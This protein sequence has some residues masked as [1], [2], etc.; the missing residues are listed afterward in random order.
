MKNWTKLLRQGRP[1]IKMQGLQN[2]F[3]FVG[4]HLFPFKQN[5]EIRIE[6]IGDLLRALTN[7]SD[8][9]PII[10]A[11]DM[12]MRESE[13]KNMVS[14]YELDDAYWKTDQAPEFKYTWDSR[15]NLYREDAFQFVCRFDRIFLSNERVG[16]FKL[17]GNHPA[18]EN[19]NHFI[20]DHFG[21]SAEIEL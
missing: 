12:N 2:H 8:K 16:T 20:S 17:I 14:T 3:V 21:I 5:A 7:I 10:M 1:F 19:P 18:S 11:V 4:C 6:Q 9:Y 13:T 15:V